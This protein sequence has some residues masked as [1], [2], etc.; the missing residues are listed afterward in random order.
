MYYPRES[1]IKAHKWGENAIPDW[2]AIAQ[3]RNMVQVV[4]LDGEDCLQIG[5]TYAYWG[6]YVIKNA[7]GNIYPCSSDIFEETYVKGVE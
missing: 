5:S 6:D 2:L 7:R 3:A 1:G 4:D